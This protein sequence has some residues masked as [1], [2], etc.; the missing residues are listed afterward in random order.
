MRGMIGSLLIGLCALSGPACGQGDPETIGRIVE[1]GRNH[2]RVWTYLSHLC[3]EIGP[4][5]TGSTRMMQANA[6]T[7]DTFASFG[8]AGVHLQKVGEIPVRFDRGPCWVR[9]EEPV[10]RPFEFTA[11]AW[12]AGTDGPRRGTVIKAPTTMEEL[13]AIRDRLAGSWVLSKDEPRRRRRRPRPE[14]DNEDARELR[15]QLDEA[16]RQAGIAGRIVGS[17]SEGVRTDAVRGWSDLDYN[18]IPED[19]T[20]LVRR[21]DYDAMNSRIADGEEVTVAADLKHHFAEGPIP[22]FN[23]I[24]DIPGTEWPEQMVIFSAHLDSWDGPGTQ[25]AQDNGTG[26]AVVLE[27]A[28]I[29]A[30]AGVQPRRT[31]RFILWVGEEQGFLGSGGYLER[32]SEEERAN[33]SAVFVDDGGTGY[34]SGLSCTESMAPMLRQATTPV[35]EAFPDMPVEIRLRERLRGGGSDHAPFLRAGIP[36]FFWG[37]GSHGDG[38]GMSY[39]SIHHNQND[40]IEHAVEEYLVQ[41]ATCSAI[42]LYN[43]AMADTL[44]PREVRQEPEPL[45]EVDEANWVSVP[46]PLSGTW[47]AKLVGRE[48]DP[49]RGFTF[50]FDMS[51]DGRIRGTLDSEYI[52]GKL[53]NIAFDANAG[54]LTFVMASEMGRVNYRAEVRGD[55]MSGTISFDSE[56]SMNFAATRVQQ[57]VEPAEEAPG[58]EAEADGDDEPGDDDA[59][60]A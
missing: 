31:I 26:C 50:A 43:L 40:R 1:E 37:E 21:S 16:L 41:S 48:E 59:G 14:N 10:G 28:R 46:G 49:G 4:R 39:G 5:V 18:D 3:E 60:G 29:L 12:S 30:A 35:A 2:S 23:T 27:A 51:N 11:P 47:Q 20:I 38:R 34:Q 15:R 24:A 32:L 45:E 13:E 22:L 54:V 56:F 25:G 36:G 55:E 7:R 19:V 8:M 58:G 17:P 42:T 52:G 53:R 6:W 57:E 33:L 9:M 44:L